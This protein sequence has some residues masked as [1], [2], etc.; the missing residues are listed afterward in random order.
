[1]DE[2]KIALFCVTVVTDATATVSDNEECLCLQSAA[3]CPLMFTQLLDIV[4]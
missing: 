4:H 2:L 3:I 1:M